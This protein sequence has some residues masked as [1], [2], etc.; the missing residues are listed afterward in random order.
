MDLFDQLGELALASRLKRLSDEIMKDGAKIYQNNNIDFEPKHFP[1]FYILNQNGPLGIMEI[2]GILGISH[3]GV[4]QL[5]KGMEKK[6]LV[7]S[8]RDRDDGRKRLLTLTP[9]GKAMA[10]SL[11]LV[12][13]D[14]AAGIH[15]L[16]CAQ[17]N[18]LLDAV[19]GI[20][21]ALKNKSLSR[22]VASINEKRQME[23]VEIVDYDI[24]YGEDF[25]KINYWW[26]EKY[27]TVENIDRKA[28]DN[29]KA[30]IIDR[31]GQILFAKYKGKIVGTC[32][33]LF[34]A[35]FKK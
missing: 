22:R 29:H 28:L 14:I 9:K 8:F 3:P 10:P 4:I 27:F 35:H 25:K 33:L 26:I 7:T 6:K 19:T 21:K 2:S 13:R 17:E 18:N 5:V 24:S 30:Y 34:S 1:V 15:E 16:I 11:Q 20:E 23:E 32:A 31:G 12:W